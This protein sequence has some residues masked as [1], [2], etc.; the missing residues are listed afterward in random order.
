MRQGEI[1]K[2]RKRHRLVSNKIHVGGVPNNNKGK[3]L[4]CY[5]STTSMDIVVSRVRHHVIR[6]FGDEWRD[7]DQLLRAKKV[8][9]IPK[10]EAYV[11]HTHDTVT[12]HGC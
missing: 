3:E 8:N 7:K 5:L 4:A 2:I 12:R 10:D 1:L 6:T 11:F 9:V